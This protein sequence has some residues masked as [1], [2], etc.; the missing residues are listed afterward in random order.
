MLTGGYTP[1]TGDSFPVL[2][3]VS[4]TGRFATLAGDGV[5]F[6][7]TYDPMAVVLVAN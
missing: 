4:E 7:A 3:F 1:T 5:L 6:T 2:T